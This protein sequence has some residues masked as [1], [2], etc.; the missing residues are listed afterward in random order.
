MAILK[1]DLEALT[2]KWDKQASNRRYKKLTINNINVGYTTKF[3]SKLLEKYDVPAREK[4]KVILQDFI[5]DNPNVYMQD[6]IINEKYKCKYKFLEIQVCASWVE[7][8]FCFANLWVY[9]RKTKYDKDTLFLT[10]SRDLKKGY[11]FNYAS[12]K[13]DKL[14]RLKKYSREIIY[15]VDWDK[16]LL[17][18]IDTLDVDTMLFY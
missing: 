3:S 13:Q 7:D 12:I 11:L 8:K 1:E 18:Y 10:L 6:F 14:K 9:A 2:K 4:L 5:Q 16:A 17:V 15:D